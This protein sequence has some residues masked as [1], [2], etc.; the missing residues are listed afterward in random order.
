MPA[1][2]EEL[3]SLPWLSAACTTRVILTRCM[4]PRSQKGAP[5]AFSAIIRYT[6]T[7]CKARRTTCFYEAIGY[8]HP[9]NAAL[10]RA[11]AYG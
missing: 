8:L 1:S 6:T 3:R 10:W 4:D 7:V 9:R 2:V 5:T 11:T